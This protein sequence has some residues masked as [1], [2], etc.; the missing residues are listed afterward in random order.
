[1]RV[2]VANKGQYV[3]FRVGVWK[4]P[5]AWGIMLADLAK[6]AANAYQQEENRDRLE[7]LQR[8]KA[9]FDAE[10]ASLTDEAS[11]AN[12]ALM[13]KASTSTG[14]DLTHCNPYRTPLPLQHRP[15]LKLSSSSGNMNYDSIHDFEVALQKLLEEEASSPSWH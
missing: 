11:G 1:V 10:W 14:S 3:S 13:R 8:I 2:W 12:P 5:A 4:D 6:H 15:R 9:P 7:T